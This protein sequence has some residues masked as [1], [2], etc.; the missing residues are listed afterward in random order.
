[1]VMSEL[2]LDIN[3]KLVYHYYRSPSLPAVFVAWQQP[4]PMTIDA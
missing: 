4:C 3:I 1:M 2:R